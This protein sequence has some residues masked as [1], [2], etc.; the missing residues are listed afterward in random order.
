M[1]DNIAH[2]VSVI[3]K[4]KLSLSPVALRCNPKLC[5]EASLYI[6]KI[7][8]PGGNARM[9]VVVNLHLSS[10]KACSHL[11]VHSNILCFLVNF[12][13][14]ETVIENSFTNRR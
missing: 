8:V 14:G 12:D 9:G 3:E 1:W 5:L 4:H 7:L 10:W 11:T 6:T 13:N 2:A